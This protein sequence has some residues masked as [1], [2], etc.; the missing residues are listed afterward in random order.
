V[1]GPRVDEIFG[2]PRLA[3]LYDALDS[4]RSDLD[5]Y[6][7]VVEEYDAQRILDVGSG[8]G[9][10]AILLAG[11]GLDV[12]ALDPADASLAVARSKPGA[13]RVRW[14]HGD[15]T[16]LPSM[17]VDLVTM[18]GNVAQAIVD[19]ADWGATLAGAHAALRPGGL[20]VFETR[21]PAYQAWEE[22]NRAA[23]YRMTDIDGVGQVE[24]W[25]ELTEMSLPLVTF[26]W[27]WAFAAD[28]AV[29]TSDS[30]LRFRG[31]EEVERALVSQGYVLEDVRD[32]PD[33]PGREMVFVARRR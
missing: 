11:S 23:S 15:V 12:T 32:A 2:N 10:F 16:S 5:L 22:W 3:A 9:T 33:R 19:P 18:T 17:Q 13:D 28:G 8:T 20:L 14:I 21:D 6:L 31:R 7:S 1:S 4:D 29:L 27:T 26:R 25:V 24:S 30:T